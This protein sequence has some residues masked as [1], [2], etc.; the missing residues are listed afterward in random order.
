MEKERDILIEYI[1]SEFWVIYGYMGFMISGNGG[2][3][4]FQFQF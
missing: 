2:I 1:Y 3:E 4:Q